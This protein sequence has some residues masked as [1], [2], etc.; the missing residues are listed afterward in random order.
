MFWY[1]AAAKAPRHDNGTS[2][3]QPEDNVVTEGVPGLAMAHETPPSHYG[4]KDPPG[5]VRSTAS[6]SLIERRH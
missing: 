3:V 1:K 4:V 6:L 5:P 2:L